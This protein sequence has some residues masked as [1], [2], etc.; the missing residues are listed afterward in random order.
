MPPPLTPVRGIPER[1]E[2]AAHWLFV[3]AMVCVR[4]GDRPLNRTPSHTHPW[5][6][7][8]MTV[9]ALSPRRNPG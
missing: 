3:C 9:R 1:E 8:K 2:Y 5:P 4:W 6:P 7:A